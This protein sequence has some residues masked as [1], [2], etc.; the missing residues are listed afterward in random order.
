MK[1]AQ[2]TVLSK[3]RTLLIDDH[4]D[5]IQKSAIEITQSLEK[6]HEEAS[7]VQT[8]YKLRRACGLSLKQLKKALR[9]QGTTPSDTRVYQLLGK[10]K[11]VSEGTALKLCAIFGVDKVLFFPQF[12]YS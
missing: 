8:V 12:F 7:R 9:E 4:K 5:I 6:L 3:T 2:K 11:Q 10:K 1:K